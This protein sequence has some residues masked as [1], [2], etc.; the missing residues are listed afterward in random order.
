MNRPDKE[1]RKGPDLWV[2]LLTWTGLAS[3]T[4]LVAVLFITAVAKPQV[5]TFFDR[6]YNLHLRRS[7][8]MELMQYIFYL[9]LV[10]LFCSLGGLIINS[11]RKR[12]KEDHIR[13]SLIVML[14]ISIFGLIQYLILISRQG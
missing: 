13:A 10:C 3:G 12:R 11:R 6:F 14:C 1:R 7:W 5:E 9:L 2:R 8:D 4:S